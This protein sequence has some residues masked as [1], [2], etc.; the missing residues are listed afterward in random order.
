[1][2]LLHSSPLLSLLQYY[3]IV[4]QGPF[5]VINDEDCVVSN[6]FISLVQNDMYSNASITF[7]I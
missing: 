1:M 7:D 3:C 5:N 2:K 4:C 6:D